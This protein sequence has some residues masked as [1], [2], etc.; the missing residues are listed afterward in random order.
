MEINLNIQANM[1]CN[2]ENE[3]IFDITSSFFSALKTT[4]DN[5]LRA[6]GNSFSYMGKCS[7]TRSSL[8]FNHCEPFHHKSWDSSS[9][10]RNSHDARAQQDFLFVHNVPILSGKMDWISDTLL[11]TKICHHSG[12]D[13]SNGNTICE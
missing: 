9:A 2:L 5:V 6:F 3:D 8:F 4:K 11:A 10:G 7:C 13:V 1:R 12:F